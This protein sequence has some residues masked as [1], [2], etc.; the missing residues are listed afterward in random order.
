MPA[1][2]T[3]LAS[4]RARLGSA[5]IGI[6]ENTVSVTAYANRA[7]NDIAIAYVRSNVISF[8]VAISETAVLE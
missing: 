3:R 6:T 8:Y 1:T 2:H 4:M 7:Y 5:G